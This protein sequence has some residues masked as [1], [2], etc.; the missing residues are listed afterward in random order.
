M[1]PFRRY[2]DLDLINEMNR[3]GYI[4]RRTATPFEIG[5]EGIGE[6]PPGF[7]AAALEVIRPRVSAEHLH[8][9]VGVTAND[10]P[11]YKATLRIL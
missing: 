3:R 2:S 9:Q 5:A 1:N 10:I 8:V 7:E 4:C 6:K 11:F